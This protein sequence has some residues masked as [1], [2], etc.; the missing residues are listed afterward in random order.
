MHVP[1]FDF[2]VGT[3]ASPLMY[4]VKASEGP[5][6][7]IELW[8]SEVSVAQK[9]DGSDRWRMPATTSVLDPTKQAVCML[10]NPFSPHGRERYR[11]DGGA[12]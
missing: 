4:V 11:E 7:L 8:E 6:G 3:G 2:S 1:G 5:G 9:F 12:R 10:P